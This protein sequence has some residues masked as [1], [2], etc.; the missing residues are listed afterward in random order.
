MNRG[1][2]DRCLTI[3][4]STAHIRT[5]FGFISSDEALNSLRLFHRFFISYLASVMCIVPWAYGSKEKK[6]LF[7]C[8]D[9]P[10]QTLACFVEFL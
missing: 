8:H 10:E 1:D 6:K 7:V 3:E 5:I 2:I 9:I 4:N